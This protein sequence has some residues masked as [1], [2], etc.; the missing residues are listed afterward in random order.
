MMV[1]AD[2]L[3]A[4]L[5]LLGGGAVGAALA[6]LFGALV[7]WGRGRL[8]IAIVG[9]MAAGAGL[10]FTYGGQTT[11]PAYVAEAQASGLASGGREESALKVLHDRFPADY[12]RAVAALRSAKGAAAF[13]KVV[14]SLIARE[15][16]MASAENA[17]DL[18]KLTRH[19]QAAC[20]AER[21][22]AGPLRE[23]KLRLA[24][25][26]FTQTALAPEVR[27][28]AADTGERL[29]RLAAAALADL[30]PAERAALKRGSARAK[31]SAACDLRLRLYDAML[32]APEDEAA[33][34]FKAQS[35]GGLRKA[36]WTQ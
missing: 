3:V 35:S 36:V 7:N 17:V 4:G 18:I 8:H 10:G 28:P 24:A 26:L 5:T 12:P 27:V 15:L 25:R 23:E 31:A 21:L 30:P 29:R 19:E 6:G 1:E 32:L 14:A 34:L 22:T 9:G 13:D 20:R 11:M 33:A 16:P 2:Q